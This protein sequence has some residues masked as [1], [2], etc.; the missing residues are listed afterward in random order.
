LEVE[1]YL[2]KDVLYRLI[3]DNE[4]KSPALY[5]ASQFDVVSGKLP[6]NWEVNQLK[7]GALHFGPKAWQEP[8]FWEDCYDYEPQALEVYK[9]EARIIMG[10][11]N[12]F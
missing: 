4:N 1:V 3:G 8:G 10:E 5:N 11:E 2:G 6:V 12:G 7:G 9:R